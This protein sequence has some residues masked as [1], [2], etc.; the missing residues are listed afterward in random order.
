MSLAIHVLMPL[1]YISPLSYL[2]VTTG[3]LSVPIDQ[4]VFPRILYKQNN[5]LCIFFL[6]SFIQHKYFEIH[7]V[8][9]TN[10]VFLF[11]AEKYSIVSIYQGLLIYSIIN[12]H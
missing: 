4:L 9:F 5:A 10:N 11:I 1:C 6:I 2:Q 12:G 3:L 8:E 7:I